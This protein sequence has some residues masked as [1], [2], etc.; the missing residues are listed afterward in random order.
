MIN[1]LSETILA[2]MPL[3]RNIVWK[4]SH[5]STE[6]FEHLPVLR[7]HPVLIRYHICRLYDYMLRLFSQ[8]W[9]FY[10]KHLKEILLLNYY[11]RLIMNHIR[12]CRKTHRSHHYC[13]LESHPSAFI[14]FTVNH[15]R[16]SDFPARSVKICWLSVTSL[17]ILFASLL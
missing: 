17:A 16:C 9:Y 1:R 15:R 3:K 11:P 14:T 4:S 5:Y 2:H 12:R 8:I 10:R 7:R 6:N 13:P